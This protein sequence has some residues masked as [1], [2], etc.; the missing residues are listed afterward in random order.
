L[1]YAQ[2]AIEARKVVVVA[3][4]CLAIENAGA[5]SPPGERFDDQR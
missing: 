3:A 1:G 4:D 5:A 2:G